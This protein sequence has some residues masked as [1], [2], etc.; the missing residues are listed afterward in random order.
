MPK[1][2]PY[3]AVTSSGNQFEFDFPLHPETGSGVD[4]FNLL[5]VVL[6]TIDREMHQ[7][8]AASNGDV[9]QALAMALAVR[10]RILP[11]NPDALAGLATRLLNDALS[12][13]VQA[14]EGNV[15]PG[16]PRDVH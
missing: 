12:A 1:R 6:G 3:K 7:V 5:T 8:G 16:E 13:P 14:A 10:T 2:L 11:G 4:V 15:M 9:L